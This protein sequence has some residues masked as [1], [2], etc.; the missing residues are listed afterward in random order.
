MSRSSPGERQ[1]PV[2]GLLRHPRSGAPARCARHPEE[3]RRAA[4]VLGVR[5]RPRQA[6][7][8]G[9]ALRPRPGHSSPVRPCSARRLGRGGWSQPVLVHGPGPAAA[10]FG[11]DDRVRHCCERSGGLPWLHQRSHPGQTTTNRTLTCIMSHP[12]AVVFRPLAS[13]RVRAGHRRNQGQAVLPADK[14]GL[15]C[16]A[17]KFPTSGT[18]MGVLPA[19]KAGLHCGR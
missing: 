18:F 10:A 12:E 8:A 16:G 15:H 13:S 3:P 11:P 19:D 5:V 9:A 14:A 2:P 1:A 6:R 17:R 7:A 4:A